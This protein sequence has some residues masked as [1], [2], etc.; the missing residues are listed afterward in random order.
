MLAASKSYTDLIDYYVFD[1]E[2]KEPKENQDVRIPLKLKQR[3]NLN[4]EVIRPDELSTDFIKKF[5]KNHIYSRILSKTENIQSHFRRYSDDPKKVINL[6]GNSAEI[7]RCFYGNYRG[8]PSKKM[9][10]QFS[11]YPDNDFIEQEI[12]AWYKDAKKYADQIGINLLDLFYWEQRMG[13]WGA[14][15]PYEQDMA[16]DEISPFNNHIL[17]ETLYSAGFNARKKPSHPIFKKL[18]ASLWRDLLSEPI[19]PDDSL[20]KNALKRN[21][22]IHYLVLKLT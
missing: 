6:N 13:N 17:I 12:S 2:G 16:I 11:G 22:F 3:F 14:Q 7:L 20:I 5:S 19:N 18:I 10:L 8:I 21:A 1:R 15:F 9:L 4:F